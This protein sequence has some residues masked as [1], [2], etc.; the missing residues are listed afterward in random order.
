MTHGL[1]VHMMNTLS[2]CDVHDSTMLTMRIFGG[3]TVFYA[4]IT[5]DNSEEYE[6]I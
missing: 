2:A 1:L 6:I 4:V 3:A 5:V